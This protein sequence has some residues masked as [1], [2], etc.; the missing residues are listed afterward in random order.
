MVLAMLEAVRETLGAA[1][2]GSRGGWSNGSAE[3]SY[4][5]PCGEGWRRHSAD[6]VAAPSLGCLDENT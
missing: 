6:G 3:T 1:D 4:L 5:V 2:K